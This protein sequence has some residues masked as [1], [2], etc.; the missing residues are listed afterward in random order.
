[1]SPI[2]RT[3]HLALAGLLVP[4]AAHGQS[5][6]PERALLN[7]IPAAY[8]VVVL[9]DEST[10]PRIDGEQALLGR[11]V[12]DAAP[13]LASWSPGAAEI[14]SGEQAL[15]GRSVPSAQRRLTLKW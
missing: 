7:A 14:V 8:R 3:T 2:T 6:S 12:G 5:I 15:L 1:M 11:R 10:T 4:L 9:G 13:S